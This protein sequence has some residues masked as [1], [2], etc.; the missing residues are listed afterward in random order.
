MTGFTYKIG[1]NFF[2]DV[3]DSVI[4]RDVLLLVYCSSNETEEG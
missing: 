3:K 1:R 2:C 4:S